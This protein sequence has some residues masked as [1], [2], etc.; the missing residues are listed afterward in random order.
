MDNKD[1]ENNN[2]QAVDENHNLKV[3]STACN[4][5]HEHTGFNCNIINY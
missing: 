5:Q 4:Y 3:K 2:H 1:Q